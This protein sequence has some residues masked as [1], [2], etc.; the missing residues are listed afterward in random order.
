MVLI[1]VKK[2]QSTGGF[3][4]ELSNNLDRVILE[5]E[6]PALSSWRRLR[7]KIL[8]FWLERSVPAWPGEAPQ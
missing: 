4:H 1:G 7:L 5:L 8:K 6:A 3:D 2:R